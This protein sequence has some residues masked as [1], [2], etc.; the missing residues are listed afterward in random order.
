M[1]K[2]ITKSGRIY[3]IL[4]VLQHETLISSFT[5]VTRTRIEHTLKEKNLL[6]G[7]LLCLLTL[8][9]TKTKKTFYNKHFLTY[10]SIT[11]FCYIVVLLYCCTSLAV[12]KCK[13]YV[14]ACKWAWKRLSFVPWSV[15]PF[16]FV[17]LLLILS[18][19]WVLK[20]L[21]ILRIC[22]EF[23]K[24]L[25]VA[26]VSFNYSFVTSDTFICL[27]KETKNIILIDYISST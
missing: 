19:N 20:Y 3:K 26:V 17:G 4:H 11:I 21:S 25:F 5:K 22:I 15:C 8:S 24:L 13:R 12:S 1:L 7:E 6:F 27:F 16:F 23:H 14:L 9:A 2:F 18:Y 10:I